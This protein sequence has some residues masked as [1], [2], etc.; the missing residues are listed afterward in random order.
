MEQPKNTGLVL[1]VDEIVMITHRVRAAE[2]LRDLKEM[3]I[4]ATLRRHDNTVCVLRMYVTVPP[5]VN[6]VAAANDEPKL[7]SSKK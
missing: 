3:G 2:Q 6:S 7:K 4:P 5:A 1:S